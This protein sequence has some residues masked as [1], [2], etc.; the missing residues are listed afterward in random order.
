MKMKKIYLMV[1][2]MAICLPIFSADNESVTLGFQLSDSAGNLGMGLEL[3]TPSFAGDFLRVRLQSQWEMLSAYRNDPDLA[4]EGFWT[5]RIGL[6]GMDKNVEA[7][8]LLYGEFGALMVQPAEGL[9]DDPFQMGIYGLFGF[10]FLIKDA[11]LSYY[12]EAGTNSLFDKAEKLS[13]QPDYLTG[14]TLV[15]GLRFY[16]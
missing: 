9:S 3:G 10:E 6:I 13:N 15:T 14:F 12:L 1:L 16:L 8:V 11:P 7:P 5:H 4:F 2:L